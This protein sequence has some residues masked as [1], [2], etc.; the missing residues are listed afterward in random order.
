MDSRSSMRGRASGNGMSFSGTF[1]QLNS[2]PEAPVDSLLGELKAGGDFD[3][4]H[5][6][7]LDDHDFDG[8]AR[9]IMF[10]KIK[11]VPMDNA[12]VRYSMS[13]KP[14]KSQCSVFALLGSPYTTDEQGRTSW[15]LEYKIH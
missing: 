7:G 5:T 10:T 11:T 15:L 2:L 14:A 4:F 6:M 13:N 9:E 1:N 3:G 8:L 12:N